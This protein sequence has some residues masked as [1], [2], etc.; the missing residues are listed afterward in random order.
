MKIRDFF[1]LDRKWID[2]LDY[3]DREMV[4]LRAKLDA[5]TMLLRWS[6]AINTG[7]IAGLIVQIVLHVI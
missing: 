7:L 6:L 5:R 3:S 2:S 4:L 1:L